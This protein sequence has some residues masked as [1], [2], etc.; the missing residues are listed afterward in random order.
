MTTKQ[1]NVLAFVVSHPGCT[2]ADVTR[3]EWAGRGHVAS[4]ARVSRLPRRGMLA[5]VHGPYRGAGIPLAITERGLRAL[6]R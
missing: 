4:Y 6:S 2:A 5:V 1:I 3:Y